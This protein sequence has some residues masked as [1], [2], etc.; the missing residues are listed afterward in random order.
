MTLP[1]RYLAAAGLVS[2]APVTL[3]EQ[4]EPSPTPSKFST[5]GAYFIEANGFDASLVSTTDP[6]Q[7][8]KIPVPTEDDSLNPDD[9]F[10]LSPNDNWICAGRHGGSCLRSG[11]LYHR[12]SQM[13][14]ERVTGFDQEAWKQGGKLHAMKT[15]W[16]A[17]GSCAMTFFAGWSRDSGRLL[18]GLL[19]GEDRRSTHFGYLYFNTKTRHFEISDYLR[20]L[21][22]NR[23]A[24]LP[25]AE[26]VDAL[27]SK[28]DL[29]TRSDALDRR[30]NEAYSARLAKN[31]EAAPQIRESQRGWVKALGVGLKLYLSTTP[32]AERESRKLQFV[33]DV[34]EARID[35][36]QQPDEGEPF[37]FWERISL[38]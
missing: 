28:A 14:I 31:P 2:L 9:E 17:D 16:L 21:N 36:L 3:A 12:V 7:R 24:A 29:Q 23:S 35:S 8:I 6:T 19:G 5:S 34:A 18:I 25:C 1:I 38:K 10:H 22:A 37:D 32:A 11:D 15:D 20:K 13:S 27:P 4:P 30:L 33:A 26:P